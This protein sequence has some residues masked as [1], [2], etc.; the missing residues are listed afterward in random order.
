M[1]KILL[2][3]LSFF[4]FANLS[5]SYEIEDDSIVKELEKT[6]KNIVE[7][8]PNFRLNTFK[9]CEDLEKVMEKYIKEYWKNNKRRYF[10]PPMILYDMA[11]MEEWLKTNTIMEKKVSVSEARLPNTGWWT[12]YSKTNTQVAWV[13]EADIIKTDWNY[14]YYYNSKGNYWEPKFVYIIDSKDPKNLKIVKKIKIPKFFNKVQ[15]FLKDDRLVILASWYSNTNYKNYWINRNRKTYVIVY[16]IKDRKKPVLKKLYINDGSLSKS[17]LIWDK[18]YVIS[19]NYF[20]IP[21]YS[22]KTE[23]DI[24]IDIKKIIPKKIDISK[25]NN[26][27]KQ[28]LKIKGRTYPFNVQAWNIAKCNEIEYVLPDSETMKKYSFN[29]SY[30]IISIV[31]INDTEKEVKTKVIAWNTSEIYMSLNNLYITDRIYLEKKYSCAWDYCILPYYPSWTTNTLIHKLAISWDNLEYK[32]SALVPWKPLNQYSMDEKDWFFRIITYTNSWNSK[33]NNS[34]TDL[35]ILDENLKLYSNLKN[36]WEKEKFQSARFMWDKL[37]L[38]TFKQIDP[39]FVIDLSNQKNPKIIWELKIPGYSRYLHPYDENHLIWLGYDTYE[40]KWGWTSNWW[41]KI[42]LYEVNYDKKDAKNPDLIEVKQLQSL[43]LWDSWSSTEALNNPRMFMWNK[44]KNLL[45]LPA[46]IYVNESKDSYKH[47]DFFQGL[48]AINITKNYIK[49]KYR[50]SHIDRQKAEEERLKE[51]KEILKKKEEKIKCRKLIDGSEYCPP[52]DDYYYI[53]D[54]C[55]ADATTGTYIAS[56]SWNYR[57]YFIK[58]ALWIEDN[59][60]AISN[61]KTTSHDIDTWEKVWEV[62]MK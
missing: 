54:Y 15:L 14:I 10:E 6:E 50:I 9:S 39:L 58:R 35:F 32:N 11:P 16:D 60:F 46:R 2:L 48:I 23:D 49:E 42:D 51:C 7:P 62:E 38:V 17:R 36:I 4:L 43:V 25:T 20:R 26:K 57:D 29:P 45:L 55:F 12:D 19:T 13:D 37:F 27:A 34:H 41:L 5:F 59:T 40:N 1:K 22:F 47:I 21:Y 18:L 31:D 53:P 24:K 8:K 33:T 44:K 56:R 61:L 52:K 28:N 30:N 3:I